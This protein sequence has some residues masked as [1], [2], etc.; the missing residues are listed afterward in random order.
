MTTFKKLFAA[1]LFISVA[2]S[3]RADGEHQHPE[4]NIY[5]YQIETVE[6][7]GKTYQRAVVTKD[8]DHS[9]HWTFEKVLAELASA[10][11]KYVICPEGLTPEQFQAAKDKK[12]FYAVVVKENICEPK[13]GW[14]YYYASEPDSAMI[15][16]GAR[17]NDNGQTAKGVVTVST[18][19]YV[20]SAEYKLDSQPF[21]GKLFHDR[22]GKLYGIEDFDVK[23]QVNLAYKEAFS[24]VDK[25]TDKRVKYNYGVVSKEDGFW[26]VLNPKCVIKLDYVDKL[27]KYTHTVGNETYAYLEEVYGMAY[28]KDSVG[29]HIAP[30]GVEVYGKIGKEEVRLTHNDSPTFVDLYKKGDYLAIYNKEKNGDIYVFK[31]YLH[32][33]EGCGHDTQH[34]TY[35][36]NLEGHVHTDSLWKGEILIEGGTQQKLDFGWQYVTA[37]ENGDGIYAD[38]YDGYVCVDHDRYSDDAS[39]SHHA[40]GYADK[41]AF[42]EI[43][44]QITYSYYNRFTGQK[45]TF[46]GHKETFTGHKESH[47]HEYLPIDFTVDLKKI[48]NAPVPTGKFHLY[49]DVKT[50]ID[51]TT[52]KLTAPGQLRKALHSWEELGN[53]NNRWYFNVPNVTRLTLSGV[54]CFA[55]IA[56]GTTYLTA[57][58]HAKIYDGNVEKQSDGKMDVKE[59]TDSKGNKYHVDDPSGESAWQYQYV[60][61]GIA[62]MTGAKL[63]YIDLTDAVFPVQTDLNISLSQPGVKKVLLPKSEQMWLIPDGAF[64]NCHY[65]EEL[66]IPHNYI[67][68]GSRAFYNTHAL[69]HIYTTSDPNNPEDE[70]VDN[71]PNTF[72]FASTL[73]EIEGG[74]SQQWGGAEATFF[75]SQMDKVTDIY[76]LATVAPKCGANAFAASMTYGNNGFAGNWVHPIRRENYNNNDKW[77]CV[78]HYPTDCEETQAKNYTDITRKYTLNDEVGDVDGTG[79]PMVWPRHAEFFRAYNQAV[80]GVTWGA[81]KEKAEGAQEVIRTLEEAKNHPID[82]TKNYDQAYQGW[83][84]FVLTGNSNSME[85]DVQKE[86]EFVQRDWY[87]LCVPY[88]LKKSQMLELFGIDGT[89]SGNNKVKMLGATEYTAVTGTMYPDVR[90]L[91]EVSRSVKQEKMTLH[92]SKPLLND[93]EGKNWEVVIPENG[94]GFSYKQLEGEDPVIIKGGHPF[95]VRGFIPEIWN[96]KIKNMGMYIMAVAASDNKVVAL[97]GK[98]E[99]ELPYQ[100][101]ADCF[102]EHNIPLPCVKH[103]IHARNADQDPKVEGDEYVYIDAGKTTPACYHFIGTY[104]TTTIPQYAY[105]LGKSKSTG[106]HT[107]FRSTKATTSWNPYS[108]VIIGLNDPF[109]DPEDIKKEGSIALQ[110]ILV[111][112]NEPQSDLVV[113]PGENPALAGK[114]FS[115]V[116]DE[117]G[118]GEPTGIVDVNLNENVKVNNNKVYGINGQYIGTSLKNLPKGIYIINGQK[119]VVK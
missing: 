35:C 34:Y 26:G 113:L 42:K 88:D 19:M 15:Y 72:T 118:K 10:G 13:E 63:E 4:I 85:I 18:K 74:V 64:N 56:D 90:V 79:K 21:T 75:G 77:I 103:H 65:I 27:L 50:P 59:V 73:K 5:D 66:C 69:K 9:R 110:N 97:E 39:V 62:G 46:T 43:D 71:G 106:K 32:K 92:L 6:L 117:E 40:H 109:Y 3:A 55:D 107:F 31:G 2:I 94:Q 89:N 81:W 114:P 87:T 30:N 25:T 112:W 101:N 67:K 83:H 111:E 115:F 102:D 57:N 95:L 82:N 86:T 53:P 116:I 41:S 8:H 17:T 11:I 60:Q 37:D 68:I 29:N 104:S 28:S 91:T 58:G 1:L 119:F 23:K 49:A 14:V 44:A 80:N 24:Y 108:A 16:T 52:N 98:T 20:E 93:S 12:S 7:D 78:L 99:Q 54:V 70:F 96:E 38:L 36:T 45:E 51:D 100:F 33:M 61:A 47:Y 22:E 76:V 105:Y 84:E 48:P